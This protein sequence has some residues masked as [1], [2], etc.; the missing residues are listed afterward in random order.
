MA[1]SCRKATRSS[2]PPLEFLLT[3][4]RWPPPQAG[5][6]MV[7]VQ[8]CIPL[9]RQDLQPLRRVLQAGTKLALRDDA[10]EISLAGEWEQ[11]FPVRFDVIAE[12]YALAF[13]GR[14]ARR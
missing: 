9:F 6:E 1:I 11:L 13:P 10:F 5:A 2:F 12:Q 3:R 4:P 8:K 7:D 14:M